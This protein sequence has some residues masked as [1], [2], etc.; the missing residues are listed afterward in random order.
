MINLFKTYT[1]YENLMKTFKEE[2]KN[3]NQNDNFEIKYN[4]LIKNIESSLINYI[5][6]TEDRIQSNITEIKNNDI[7][8][9]ESQQ[10]INDDL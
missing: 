2:L 3:S 6:K 8:N 9:N 7:K 1:Q 5:S 10:K 4:N